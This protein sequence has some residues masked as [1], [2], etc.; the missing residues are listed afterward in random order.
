MLL[1]CNGSTQLDILRQ[2]NVHENMIN[3]INFSY[4]IFCLI[5][6]ISIPLPKFFGTLDQNVFILL[7]NNT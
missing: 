5:Q 7:V 6:N 2:K 4:V 1:V 3:F